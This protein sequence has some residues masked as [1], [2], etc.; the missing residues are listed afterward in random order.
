MRKQISIFLVFLLL[1][2]FPA[3]PASAQ[4]SGPV[5]IVQ[6]GDTL[7]YIASRFNVTMD[8][9]V[10]ANP[11]L[12]P[13][14]LSE[15]QEI[16]I[17]GL[18]GVTGV[19]ETEI[20]S[21]GD[22]LRSLSRRTQVS[23]EQLI[24]LNRL[25]SP[26]ELYVGIS[27]IIPTQENQSSLNT[28]IA[29]SA[30][31]SLLELAVRQN[32][33]PWS[34]SALNKLDGTWGTLPGDVLYS[35][36]D[37]NEGNATGLPSAFQGASIEPLPLVQGGTE[38]IQI[39]TQDNISLSG[40]LVDKPLHFSQN[41]GSQIALQ[42]VHALLEPGVYPLL[43]EATLPDATKQ[44]FEQMV[45]I[46]EGDYL[47]E[48]IPLNDPS[49][50]DTAVTEPELQ[51][52]L[53]LTTPFTPTRYWNGTFISPAVDPNCFTSR[54]GTRRTYNVINSDIEVPGFHTGLDFCGGEGLQIFA[55]APGR[56][57]FAAPLT[58]RG[59]ATIIDHGWGIYSGFWHQ[60][61]ILVNVG[62]MIE[63]GQVIGVVGGTGRVT[64][65]HLHWEVWVNGIQ[66]N[67]LDWLSQA[68][69]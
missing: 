43:V 24:K 53:A 34:L 12:D 19:L 33:D 25:I 22:S 13:N 58:V 47:S 7:S 35:P 64:G 51:N 54:Y 37:N 5:Y 56:V 8:E 65:A 63:E 50:L 52:I 45:L 62:D 39:Q 20:I 1:L 67:P 29:A 28:R 44:S 57:V 66:V 31:E 48:V 42:G 21:F 40:M 14:F 41:D 46:T 16:V 32:R 17:P 2:S 59:N 49:T 9:L 36:A 55:P 30:G 26:T 4:S 10:A 15:G 3:Q 38:I 18:E 27:L 6:P 11:S 23:D 61:Q 68:Y 69:P 60:S